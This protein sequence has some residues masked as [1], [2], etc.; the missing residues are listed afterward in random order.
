MAGT[1]EAMNKVRP[2]AYMVFKSVGQNRLTTGERGIVTIPME[3]PWGKEDTLIEVTADDYI[4]GKTFG[5]LGLKNNGEKIKPLREIFKN[6]NTAKVYKLNTGGAAA[7]ADL[8]VTID[9]SEDT[10][11]IEAAAK[12]TL[13]NS[14]TVTVTKDG[15]PGVCKLT[16]IV[17]GTVMDIQNLSAI[18]SYVPNGWITFTYTAEQAE[19]DITPSQTGNI[20]LSGGTDGTESSYEKFLEAVSAENWNV[21]AIPEDLSGNTDLGNKIAD[22]IKLFREQEGKKVQAV[23]CNYDADHEGIICVDQG[24]KVMDDEIKPEYFVGWAAGA[25]AGAYL[26][27]SNTY[28]V[29]EN[30]TEIINPK[31]TSQI[32]AGLA[33]GKFMLSRR[34]DRAIVVEKDINSYHSFTPEKAY[35]FSKNRVIRTLDDIATEVTRLFE[36]SYIGKVSN[37]VAGRT[38]FKGDI[39]GYLTQLEALGAIVDFDSSIDIEVLAGNDIESIVVNLAVQAVDAME[40]LYMT[41]VVS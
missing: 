28:K 39:A 15:A 35:I 19:K 22:K 13:G 25:T 33:A 40:K 10:I 24:Y 3:L 30:A 4:Q 38:L 16:T 41:V 26:N 29:V 11:G 37:N 14:I 17:G 34:Q 12:G 36:N 1:F 9:G 2:G 20:P 7:K 32:E 6:C 31:S 18:N 21:M 8:T 23:L 5:K 27:Q